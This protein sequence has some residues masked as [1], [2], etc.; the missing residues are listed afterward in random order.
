[1]ATIGDKMMDTRLTWFGHI[2]RRSVNAQVRRYEMT[3]PPECRKRKGRPRNYWNEVI[4][5]DLKYMV[6][7]KDMTQD[8]SF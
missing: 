6:L 2:K 7:T 5:Y 1:M 4:K 3:I 8:K